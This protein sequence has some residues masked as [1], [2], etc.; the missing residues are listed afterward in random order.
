MFDGIV[1]VRPRPTAQCPSR[2][3]R[4]CCRFTSGGRAATPT[5]VSAINSVP[6]I[7]FTGYYRG[8]ADRY[9]TKSMCARA[10]CGWHVILTCCIEHALL[11]FKGQMS[12]FAR[13]S[14]GIPR[15]A[16]F[17]NYAQTLSLTLQYFARPRSN[18]NI[19]LHHPC[20]E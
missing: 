13:F 8:T 15:V 17:L 3:R 18:P 4:S 12:D 1:L 14:R 2:H 5:S 19:L 7:G 10:A 16:I 6:E 20:V 9:G 11:I